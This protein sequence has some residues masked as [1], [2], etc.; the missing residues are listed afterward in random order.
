MSTTLVTG[1]RFRAHPTPALQ[2]VL[3]QW[4]G[5]QRVV[6]NAKV[7]EDRLF[8][9]QRRLVLAQD[10]EAIV[11]TPL[12]QQY[13]QFKSELTP[14]LSSVPAQV[15]RNGAYRWMQAKQRQLKNL[16]KAP[17]TRSRHNFDSVL[18]TSELFRFIELP[19][20]ASGEVRHIIE[21]GTQKNPIGRL[22]FV[23]RHQEGYRIPKMLVV[24]RHASGRWYVSFNFEQPVEAILRAPHE[25]AY[26]LNLLRDERLASCTLGLDR[27]VSANKIAGSDGLHHDFKAIEKVRLLRKAVGR[28]RHQKHL[29][30]QQKGSR[31]REKTKQRI[32]KS[33]EYGGNVRNNFAHQVSHRLSSDEGYQLYAF[34]ALQVKN[35]TRRPKAKKDPETGRWLRN[36]ASAKAALNALILGAAWGKLK[37]YLTYKAAR[38]NKLVCEVRAAY[39][40]QECSHCGHTHPGN[41][42]QH[43]FVCQHC[44]FER[45]ADHNAALVQKKRAIE[46]LRSGALSKAAKAKKSV[47]FRRKNSAGADSPSVPVEPM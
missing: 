3:S 31:N 5:C 17:T 10:P 18:L 11:H 8:A 39:S 1:R 41:R 47:A 42:K 21:L 46:K 33:H 23:A 25:L 22:P 2:S 28:K 24:R 32:A 12:D 19:D 14:W 43:A 35:M 15:L 7:C 40:S 9:A 27:N 4:I 44:G 37:Q 38:R 20:A 16:A 6:Y 36:G 29:A 30:R 34:E 45:H 26:E 13:A